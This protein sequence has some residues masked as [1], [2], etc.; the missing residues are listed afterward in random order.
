[1]TA[2]KS[3]T[4]LPGDFIIA[5]KKRISDW[6]AFK[7]ALT[8]GG[9]PALWE[10]AYQEYFYARLSY[11]YLKP[12]TV[13]QTS[14]PIRGEGFSIVAIQ[15][16]LIE[17]LESTIRG[18]SYRYSRNGNPP[19]GQYEYSNSGAIF[20]SFLANRPP[21]NAE[22]TQQHAH[23]FYVSVRCGVL[24]EARTK[25]GWTILAKSK[26]GQIIDANLKIVYR[27]D[28]QAALLKF[29]EWYRTALPSTLALQEAFLRKFD[30]LCV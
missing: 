22:F 13:L 12:L 23:D 4:R 30:G 20:E 25:N 18:K 2:N 8:V 24:H 14:G 3:T 10:K 5:G 29:A 15:C 11:R 9:N 19:L 17:F 21:F 1:M 7:G 6:Q 16:S 27:D 26:T 28:F